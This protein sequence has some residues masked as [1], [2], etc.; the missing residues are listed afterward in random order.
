MKS[1]EGVWALLLG[2]VLL[3]M[4]AGCTQT[5]LTK[6]TRSATEQLLIS[7][8]ADRALAQ[9]D[10]SIVNKKKV[11]VDRVNYD[12]LDKEYVI[13]TIH[14]YVSLNGGLLVTNMNDAELVMEPR[15]GALSIDASSSIIGLP[16]SAAPVPLAGAVNLPEMALY[17]SE[18]QYSIAKL[19]ILVYE[20]DSK[21]H[22]AS[23]GPLVGRANIKYYK[24]LGLIGYTKTTVPERL[25]KKHKEKQRTKDEEAARSKTP[26]FQ[27]K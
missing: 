16:A 12:S 27:S 18:K 10:W 15:S 11:Y 26:D 2:A 24:F 22:V 1:R 8:A 19:A 7:T 6:P 9:W 5:G 3:V 14:D 17:K 4:G 25:G 13:G 20:R 21:Q 23:T